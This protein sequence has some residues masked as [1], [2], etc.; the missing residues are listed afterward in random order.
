MFSGV[1]SSNFARLQKAEQKLDCQPGLSA[2]TRRNYSLETSVRMSQIII[3]KVVLLF[4]LLSLVVG[5]IPVSVTVCQCTGQVSM[6]SM[7]DTDSCE[8]HS[9]PKCGNCKASAKKG[10][11]STKTNDPPTAALAAFVGV[12]FA[13]LPLAQGTASVRIWSPSLA[14][15]PHLVLPRIREPDLSGHLLRAPPASA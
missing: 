7:K 1:I 4:S 13:I 12:D 9:L 8:K 2:E 11:F 3:R 15:Q 5:F 6:E 14:I 10:C